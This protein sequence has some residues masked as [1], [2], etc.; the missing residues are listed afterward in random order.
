M[1][2]AVKTIDISWVVVAY[3]VAA[4]TSSAVHAE[5]VTIPDLE[6]PA[7]LAPYVDSEKT[8]A[9]AGLAISALSNAQ[10]SNA[11]SSACDSPEWQSLYRGARLAHSAYY[12]FSSAQ[13]LGWLK[14]ESPFDGNRAILGPARE[15]VIAWWPKTEVAKLANLGSQLRSLPD[16]HKHDLREFVRKLS[17]FRNVTGKIVAREAGLLSEIMDEHKV[18]S[19]EEKK[20]LFVRLGTEYSEKTFPGESWRFA[21][22]KIQ[23]ALIYD[24]VA[25]GL[26]ALANKVR[27]PSDLRLHDCLLGGFEMIPPLKFGTE[28]QFEQKYLF[29]SKYMISFWLRRHREGTA[30]IAAY[31]LQMADKFL[32]HESDKTSQSTE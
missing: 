10:F 11:A 24:E 20:D 23:M 15:A 13:E 22:S 1:G 26:L 12:L 32:S 29:P 31:L 27:D 6:A 17:E 18:L 14:H 9:S 28:E 3:A 25:A 21:D 7:S 30:G 5:K 4:L 19:L 16:Q 8:I 2:F